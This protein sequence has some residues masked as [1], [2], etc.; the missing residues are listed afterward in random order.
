MTTKEIQDTVFNMLRQHLPL[1]SIFGIMGNISQESSWNSQEVEQ[2]SQIGFGLCQ[3]SFSRR[4]ALERY[5][6][7]VKSQCT[8]LLS[9]LDSQWFDTKGYTKQKFL[10]GS[11]SP[12]EAAAAFCW[13]FERPNANEANLSYRIREAFRFSHIYNVSASIS[14]TPN[15][16]IKQ[17]QALIN[18]NI[19]GI[20]GNET[21]SKCPLLKCGD[22]GN[23]VRWLQYCLNSLINAGIAIDGV[24]GAET[25]KAVMEYQ[26]RHCLAIDGEFGQQSW[27]TILKMG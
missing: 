5:G 10:N 6:T 14:F 24:F 4:A 26:R 23:I 7:D 15:G 18:A 25:F 1:N 20:A 3:W 9:E 12:S 2:G 8:F 21:L 19:D 17:L 22:S 16:S 27:R 13:C 11:Y